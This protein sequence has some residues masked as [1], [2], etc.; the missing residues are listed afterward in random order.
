MQQISIIPKPKTYGPLKNIPHIKK[1]E[2]SQTF[3]RLADELGPIFQ[4][5][6]SKATSIFVSSHELAK[7]VFDERRF[8]KFIGSSLNKVRTFSGDGLFTS[9]T[10]EPNWRKAHH[11]LMPAFSQQAMKGY[12][13]MMLDIATQL[14]QKWQRTGRDEEIEVAEDMTKLTLDTIGLCGFDFRF[15]S[16]YKEN[17]HPFIE[18]MLNGLNEAMDQAS[19][20]PVADKLMIKRRKEFEQDVDFMKQLVDDIIQ[21]RKKQDKTGN[22]LLSLMLHAKDPET[23]ERLSDENIR[24][25]IITFLIAGHETTSGLLSFAIYFLLKNPDKLKKAVQEADD[26][27]QGGLPT[28]KQVQKLSYTRMV[29]NEALRLWPTAPTFSLYAKEDTVIGGKYPIKKNQSVNV[30]LPKLHRDQAVWGED[31]E[32]FK[33]ERFMHPEKIPQHAYKPFGNGQR[34][35]IGMQFAL[36]EATMVLAMVLHNLELIDHTS[37]ELDLKESLTIKPNDFKIKV[38]PRKQQ[39]FMAPPKEEPTKS[40]ASA[41][42]K[43][44]S[45]GTP[46]LVLYGSNLGAAKQMANEFAEDGKAKGFDVTTAPLDD[47]TRK[48]PE[49]GAVLIVTASYNGHPPDHAKQFVD[50]V[51]QDEEQ[52]LSNVTFAV[53]GCGDRNWAST[54]QRIP[55]LIDEALERKGAKRVTDIGEGDAGGDMDE[56]KETF[57]KT[58]FDELAK[59]FNLTLQE[60]RQEKPN[61]SIA[62]TNE[63]V[64]RPVAKTYGAFSAVVLKNQELQ[65][66][67]STRQTRHIEL[68][69]PEGKH[70]KEGD[71]IGI[72]PKNSA[73]LVQRVTDR[74]K[75]DPKQHMILSSEKEASHLPI[76]QPIQVEELLASHIELQEPVTRTQLRDLAKYT[77]CPP[78]RIEL[79]QMAGETYQEAVLKKR[80]TMLDLLEQYEACELPFDHFLALLPGLKPRYYSISS[81]PKVDEKRLSITVAVVK[82]KSWSGRGEYA[83]VASNYLCGLQEGDEVACFLHEAQAGFELPAS[84]EIPMIMIGP[85]TGI[86]PFRGFIQA[87][88]AWQNEGKPLGEAH[89]YFGCRHPHEDDLYYD[90]MQLAE[91]KGVVTIHRAYSRYEEQKVYVQHFIK[92]DGAKLI[93]LL[94]KGAYLY[95]CGD[96][97]VM[98]PDVEATLIE[99]YQTEKQ[100]AKETAEQWLTSLANDNRYVKDVWS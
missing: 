88:E 40:T 70:Y 11:I 59:E 61:L 75:L 26:V 87:R 97:K 55:R 77:V 5:E 73:T 31:A 37:Y 100:C 68:Q 27:L 54:Y 69:L 34:A 29:L 28:F 49:S 38:R 51:T 45:H 82:G 20:L 1:G 86:A 39:F 17:Q 81:S 64:E 74:F 36:H 79:E 2:L 62:Y 99:L 21:E 3:W 18:S 19:R 46:L 52:D 67:K 24:Y 12:H 80:V 32:E 89:L 8:D 44:A 41:E 30:L 50:W 10:E 83:G 43:I 7:E 47:Y 56:D 25:Q 96:G 78:H 53:F 9:W 66:E 14:V 35:C 90:E 16:F 76:N 42:A 72:V 15:N 13:E 23:G 95:I 93:E 65:S 48:L 58:V 94:D 22:D 4:F 91:Q 71:H 6:F 85:G 63:L 98:A 92:N 84:P 60:K 57:Q 33:P